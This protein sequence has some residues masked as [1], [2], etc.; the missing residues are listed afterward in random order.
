MSTIKFDEEHLD[1]FLTD[2]DAISVKY[3]I[4]EES[5]LYFDVCD[6]EQ[7]SEPNVY[8]TNDKASFIESM[9]MVYGCQEDK[10]NDALWRCE[11]VVNKLLNQFVHIE[12]LAHLFNEHFVEF[13]WDMHS[14]M[15][16]ESH[17]ISY[18]RD[19]FFHQLRDCYML[20]EMLQ[21]T[22]LYDHAKETLCSPSASKISR[23]FSETLDS[24]IYNIR[25]QHRLK[26]LLEKIALERKLEDY[27]KRFR[28]LCEDDPD[29]SGYYTIIKK[30]F[31]ESNARLLK[32][33]QA[34]TTDPENKFFWDVFQALF[35]KELEN[36]GE[37]I[38]P[39]KAASLRNKID[40][41]FQAFAFPLASSQKEEEKKKWCRECE[42][43]IQDEIREYYARYIL[44]ASAY[45]AALFHDIGYPIVHYF[46]IQNRLLD[47]S[48]PINMLISSDK[49]TYDAICAK[50]SQ[51]L[52]FQ[53]VDRKDIIDRCQNGDHGAFSAI[54]LLL[55]F[56][57]S[58]LIFSLRPE[59]KAIIELAAH[60]IF[61]H[62]NRYESI[63]GVKKHLECHYQRA[64]YTLDP[65][66]FLL[67]ICDDAQEWVRTYFEISN[68]ASLIYCDR[69]RTPLVRVRRKSADSHDY[70]GYQYMCRCGESNNRSSLQCAYFKTP[71]TDFHRRIIYNVATC[72]TLIFDNSDR[73]YLTI[74]FNYD[75][76]YLL[77]LSSLSTSYAF[78]RVKELNYITNLVKGQSVGKHV[79]VDF[80]MSCNPVLLKALIL[81]KYLKTLPPKKGTA[82]VNN[83]DS[84]RIFFTNHILTELCEMSADFANQTLLDM[85]NDQLLFYLK[86]YEKAKEFW[87]NYNASKIKIR[88]S[89]IETAAETLCTGVAPGLYYNCLIKLVRDALTNLTDVLKGYSNEKVLAFEHT[90]MEPDKSLK[91]DVNYYC[92]PDNASD[93]DKTCGFFP[94]YYSDLYLF[95][96]MNNK[97]NE[98]KSSIPE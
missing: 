87:N 88:K 47:F 68:T 38:D 28:E 90:R 45:T 8:A 84:A 49:S 59:Q 72:P 32:C 15:D 44:K 11:N 46:L 62:T 40:A 30:A 93:I 35:I 58:G 63:L 34:L 91:F 70:P 60:T 69:C 85:W 92:D 5:V 12:G 66:S 18:Y 14:R 95:E 78:H 27:A 57:E 67:R 16:F 98:P 82:D 76:F 86:I 75:Y 3:D 31:L 55:H 2:F 64:I 33:E 97:I 22:Q 4:S 51:S 56:Y 96:C 81:G 1:R 89:D 83:P 80:E 6:Y 71:S 24:L 17:E 9:C 23:Y 37:Q 39:D 65:L 50:L 19:H 36:R 52:L 29:L 13:E 53:L 79:R 94:D 10:A 74:R 25:D 43:D 54:I 61:N 77:R 73:D 42:K 7:V 48:P 41:M 21:T 20:D 26:E